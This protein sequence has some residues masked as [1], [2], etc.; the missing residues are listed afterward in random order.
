MEEKIKKEPGKIEKSARIFI[1]VLVALIPIQYLF[2]W[3]LGQ[4]ADY[5]L[6]KIRESR[7]FAVS[8]VVSFENSAKTLSNEV[9]MDY[10]DKMFLVKISAL[11]KEGRNLDLILSVDF[12]GEI[13][14]EK[15]YIEGKL[16]KEIE[17]PE[18]NPI[19]NAFERVRYYTMF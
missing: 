8:E 19:V 10:S 12:F 3:P 16:E 1:A 14:A 7:E 17:F 11:I 4:D 15:I 9:E 5:L 2:Q 18:R 13:K 6:K